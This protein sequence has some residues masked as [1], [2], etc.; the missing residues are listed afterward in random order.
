[1]HAAGML[2]A[3][4]SMHAA[5]TQQA[6]MRA[7]GMLSGTRYHAVTAA[8]KATPSR[9]LC[10]RHRAFPDHVT[11]S[12]ARAGA[13]TLDVQAGDAKSELAQATSTA[14]TV[15]GRVQGTADTLARML[16]GPAST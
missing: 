8:S 3:C 5:C 4:Q 9:L 6:W 11:D 12:N 7:Q 16:R 10:P 13:C 14:K 2:S 15:S 1:M